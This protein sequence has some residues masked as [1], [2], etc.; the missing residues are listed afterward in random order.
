MIIS[1]IQYCVFSDIKELGDQVFSDRQLAHG[2]AI[3]TTIT[4]N[5]CLI[6]PP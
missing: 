3:G 5:G 6:G 1:S 4:R 2:I